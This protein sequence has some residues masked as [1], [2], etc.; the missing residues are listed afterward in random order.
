MQ[1]SNWENCFHHFNVLLTFKFSENVH[2]ICRLTKIQKKKFMLTLDRYLILLCNS[3]MYISYP[4]KWHNSFKFA[5]LTDYRC[6]TTKWR[7]FRKSILVPHFP[8]SD[9]E[10]V[11]NNQRFVSRTVNMEVFLSH[12]QLI[13]AV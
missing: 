4:L 13:V 2:N 1:I 8:L 9:H 10:K 7:S 5:N 11:G 3:N 6:N 12:L